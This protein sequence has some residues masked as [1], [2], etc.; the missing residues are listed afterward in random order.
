MNVGLSRWIAGLL[1]AAGILIAGAGLVPAAR[2][3]PA[4]LER[5]WVISQLDAEHPVAQTFTSE[6]PG[7]AGLRV[8]LFARPIDRDDPVT[9]RLRYADDGV[10][11]D[12]AAVT[13]PVR[14]LNSNGWTTFRFPP[15]DTL[16]APYADAAF[17]LLILEAPTIPPGE[18]INMIAGPDTYPAG[19]LFVA[20]EEWDFADLAFEPIYAATLLDRVMPVSI[21]AD[22]KPGL[23]GQPGFYGLICGAYLASMALALLAVTKPRAGQPLPVQNWHEIAE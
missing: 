13:V 11:P 17:L 20:D 10:T 7:L 9:L 3:G 4:P 23:F 5:N 14:E 18:G 22:G 2:T 8:L 1:L 16:A 15:F 19:R 6:R 21:L 12:L